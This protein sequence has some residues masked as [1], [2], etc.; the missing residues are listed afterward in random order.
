M[1]ELERVLR[2]LARL[3]GRLGGASD[4]GEP[5][6]PAPE[7]ADRQEEQPDPEAPERS[8]RPPSS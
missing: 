3:A 2:E 4:E 8:E 7:P 6:R 5:P 1:S